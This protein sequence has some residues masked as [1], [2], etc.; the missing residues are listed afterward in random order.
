MDD[1]LQVTTKKHNRSL[2]DRN[3]DIRLSGPKKVTITNQS[4]S[5]NSRKSGSTLMIHSASKQ[6]CSKKP[7]IKNGLGG[8]FTDK[9]HRVQLREKRIAK[10]STFKLGSVTR[11]AIIEEER[12][13]QDSPDLFE[14][15]NGDDDLVRQF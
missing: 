1:K 14:R 13:H 2:I 15:D 11:E 4:D 12:D 6:K 9:S 8:S 7:I 5:D 3:S 10:I